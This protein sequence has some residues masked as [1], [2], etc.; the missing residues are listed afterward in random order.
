LARYPG[1]YRLFV[2]FASCEP[3]GWIEC[4]QW[5]LDLDDISGV[6]VRF[7]GI[8]ARIPP[9]QV[10]EKFV[11]LIYSECDAQL[12]ALFEALPCLVANRM[13][14]GYSNHSKPYQAL[15][16]RQ[17]GFKTPP[18]LVTSDPDAARKFFEEHDGQV[19]YKSI[20]SV[21]SIVRK[22]SERHLT[23]LAL[24]R[25]GPA[26]FQALISGHDVRVHTV[27]D[28]YFATQIESTAVDYR[29]AVLEGLSAEMS[30]VDLPPA[31]ANACVKIARDF[32]LLI[33]GIDLKRTEQGEYFCFEVNPSPG[34]LY[35]EHG[36]SQPVST[37]LA[38]L[39]HQGR[40]ARAAGERTCDEHLLKGAH[41]G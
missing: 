14:G 39:L 27:F 25:H 1:D 11:P 28:H 7:P 20:S 8:E 26:Q 12:L 16:I 30:P 23:R 32:D 4:D 2:Q 10:E 35:Y 5:R 24:L 15:L 9:T 37:A 17:Y 13:V 31:V 33:A 21:R 34:F 29:Y 38:E 36:A 6:Y 18:T 41:H 40:V 22:L 19:I 3:R